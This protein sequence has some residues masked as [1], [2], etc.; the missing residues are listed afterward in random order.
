MTHFFNSAYTETT[1]LRNGTRVKLRLLRASDKARLRDGFDRLSPA[2]RYMRFFNPKHSISDDELEYLTQMDNMQHL[3]IAAVRMLD[4][5]ESDG[6]GVARFIRVQP[7]AETAEAAITVLDEIHGQGLGTLLF[8]RLI[9]A[10]AER[11]ITRFRCDILTDN[12]V[13]NDL[14]AS[15]APD[16]TFSEAQGVVS[17]EFVLPTVA[18]T[19][20]ISGAPRGSPLFNAFR[21]IADGTVEWRDATTRLVLKEQTP[22]DP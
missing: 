11:G 17:V 18:P 6:L 2:A 22:S 15:L 7:H 5:A 10:A 20:T 16:R 13:M 3:A 19:Q 9:A 8:L 1:E 14:I 4:G 21:R 12:H